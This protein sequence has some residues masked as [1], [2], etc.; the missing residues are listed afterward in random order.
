MFTRFTM[1]PVIKQ[2]QGTRLAQSVQYSWQTTKTD[3]HVESVDTWR[4][5]KSSVIKNSEYLA[6][7]GKL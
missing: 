1:L 4:R 6:V 3:G 2:K 7:Y 5:N